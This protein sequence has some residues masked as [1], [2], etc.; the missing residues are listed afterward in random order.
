[1]VS[2]V[3]PSAKQAAERSVFARTPPDG[4]PTPVY[5]RMRRLA[6]AALVVLTG[7]L[8][9]RALGV[10]RNI[11]VAAHF[12]TGTDYSAYV[13]AM[14]V[15]DTVFQV[16]VGGAVG[17]AFIPVFQRYLSRDQEEEAW[18]LTSSVINVGVLIA[19]TCSLILGI[20]AHPLMNVLLVGNPDPEFRDLATSLTRI[21]LISPAIFAAS[22]FCASVL[23]SYHRFAVAAMAPLM[24]NLAIIAGAVFLSGPFGIHG[25]AI[26]AVIGAGLHLLIQVPALRRLGMRWR[27]LL[28]LR[29]TGVQEVARLFSP[30]VFGLGV[31]QLNKV[32]SGVLFASFL[33]AGSMAYLDYAWLMIMTPL[34]LAMAVGTAV[35]PTLAESSTL[36]RDSQFQQVFHVSLRMILFLTIPASVGL[37]V[38]G[39]PIIRLFFERNQFT[40]H[41]TEATAYALFFFAIGLAGHATVEIL[42]RVFYAL[43]DTRTPVMVAVSAIGLNVVCSLILMQTPLNY[44]GLALANSIAA[45]AE[46]I[47]LVRLLSWRVPTFE[48]REVGLSTLRIVAASVV[49]AVPVAWLAR[50]FES[51]L[52]QFG[53]PGQALLVASCVLAG[54]AVYVLASYIFR[55]NELAALRRLIRR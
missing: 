14:S 13:A 46:G 42:D 50:T 16:L 6:Q 48:A 5:D 7:F 37:M 51:S 36:K 1:M 32:L 38:L 28:D 43:H 27:P 10:V 22:T 29:H 49:M 41:S 17:S 35:F 19:G 47:I 21:L 45:L 34:A 23:N 18:R 44:G 9:S 40:A 26:G 20:F 25:L 53:T 52:D 3:I 15:P 11:V 31:V 33:V 30:R 12:G 54:A 55:S 4:V 24:Y 39:Q 2:R 8:A